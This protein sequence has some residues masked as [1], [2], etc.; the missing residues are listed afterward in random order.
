[1]KRLMIILALSFLLA[2][3]ALATDIAQEQAKLLQTDKIQESLTEDT[4]SL[5]EELNPL[6]TGDLRTEATGI[7]QLSKRRRNR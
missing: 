3:P 4:R 1:M 6:N 2:T 5:L 7:I